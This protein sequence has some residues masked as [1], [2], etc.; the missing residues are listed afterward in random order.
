MKT[1]PLILAGGKGERFWPLSR[2]SRPKQ[3]LSLAGTRTMIEDAVARVRAA[4]GN[5]TP[6][7]ITGRDCARGIRKALSSRGAYHCIVEPVGKTR[8]RQSRLPR[9]GCSSAMARR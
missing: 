1:V 4:S 6:L 9:C 3:L 8:R 5:G 7:I 2:S